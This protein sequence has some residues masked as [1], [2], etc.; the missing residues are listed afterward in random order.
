MLETVPTAIS[1]AGVDE[2]QAWVIARQLENDEDGEDLA[3]TL[4]SLFDVFAR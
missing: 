3:M 1:L 2:A 4:L